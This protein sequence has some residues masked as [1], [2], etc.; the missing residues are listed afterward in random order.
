MSPAWL[1]SICTSSKAEEKEALG[2]GVRLQQ[3]RGHSR[4]A[5]SNG[6]P[7]HCTGQH[8]GGHGSTCR[9]PAAHC[10]RGVTGVRVTAAQQVVFL[11]KVR[12]WHVL[13]M[14][15][16]KE[17]GGRKTSAPFALNPPYTWTRP[18]GHVR[19]SSIERISVT[20]HWAGAGRLGEVLSIPQ[21]KMNAERCL[22]SVNRG[23]S[24]T[25]LLRRRGLLL[26][27]SPRTMYSW[28]RRALASLGLGQP[29]LLWI[30]PGDV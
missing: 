18:R 3:N 19:V 2:T 13:E 30:P 27:S 7:Q 20:V 8:S 5:P 23:I 10:H 22:H 24:K 21:K 26:N 6:G 17:L 16:V 11:L 29:S 15:H 1:P 14:F 28:G 25:A 4:S 9:V 12:K